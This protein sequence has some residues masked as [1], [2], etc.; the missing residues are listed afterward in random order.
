MSLRPFL[1]APWRPAQV[2]GCPAQKTPRSCTVWRDPDRTH[3]GL[4]EPLVHLAQRA[5][6]SLGGKQTLFCFL[7][8]H[9]PDPFPPGTSL[10]YL[11]WV[12]SKFITNSA[13]PKYNPSLVI[14]G[15]YFPPPEA[16]PT[17]NCSL[18]EFSSP[19]CLNYLIS[20]THCISIDCMPGTGPLHTSSHSIFL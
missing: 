6:V 10:P 15:S 1:W 16:A 14:H 11:F 18:I 13:F 9:H 7:N 17:L 4:Q 20:S 12:K 19:Q 2:P 5:S 3:Q 8:F